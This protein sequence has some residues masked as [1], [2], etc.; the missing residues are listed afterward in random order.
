ME[1][2]ALPSTTPGRI[3]TAKEGR[4]IAARKYAEHCKQLDIEPNLNRIDRILGA[5]GE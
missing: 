5:I 3:P 1:R 4:V 2:P